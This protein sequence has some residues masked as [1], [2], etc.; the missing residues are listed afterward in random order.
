[1]EDIYASR[2][3][4]PSP[5]ALSTQVPWSTQLKAAD[6]DWYD[7]DDAGYS[8]NSSLLDAGVLPD[9]PDAEA[10]APAASAAPAAPA[11]AQAPKPAPKAAAPKPKVK[12]R[13]G[14]PKAKAKV[15]VAKPKVQPKGRA[16]GISAM[17]GVTD[18]LFSSPIH[19]REAVAHP[20]D[21]AD[22]QAVRVLQTGGG[23]G[24]EG[25]FHQVV[26]GREGRQLHGMHR[27]ASDDLRFSDGTSAKT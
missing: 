17:D 24:G 18:D 27:H 9:A 21:R 25:H 5:L 13:A 6:P 23:M 10:A 16:Q 11:V 14:S 26:R 4:E 8:S 12:A 15:N 19:R 22:P 2:L 3:P 7:E 1:M 20:A